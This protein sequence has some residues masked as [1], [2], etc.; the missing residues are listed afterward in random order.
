MKF[1]KRTVFAEEFLLQNM[2]GPNCVRLAEEL[3]QSVPLRPGM[4]VL[5]L[6]CGTGLSS[7]FL[8]VEYEVQVF[9]ADLW[10]DPSENYQRFRQFGL[11]DRIVPLRAE[12]HALP[13]ARDY[14]DAMV[15]IDA[16]QYFGADPEYLDA[17]LVPIVKDDGII[18]V[19]VHGLQRDF[20]VVP[21][22][23]Q[24]YWVEDMNHYS[25]AW[26]KALWDKSQNITL[27]RCFSHTCHREA[28]KD[29]LKSD[30]PYAQRDIPMIEAEKGEYFDSI[31]L[32][33]TVQKQ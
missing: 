25:A 7:L 11:E 15:C 17:H 30:N 19:S 23:L 6:G 28:W 1:G 4:R 9:A 14:F 32:I 29:W 27:E 20:D 16:Y 3:L 18:A 8:A 21:A 13:F 2:M 24:P 22:V 26:W 33:A 10:V 5:D 12:A 31:G